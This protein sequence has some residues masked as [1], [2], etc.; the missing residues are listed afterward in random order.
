MQKAMFNH[1]SEVLISFRPQK[2]WILSFLVMRSERVQESETKRFK[3]K[4]FR[5]FLR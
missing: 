2:T 3:T 5:R 1:T 4:D